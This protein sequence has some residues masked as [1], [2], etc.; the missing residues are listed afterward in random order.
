MDKIIKGTWIINS[1]KHLVDAKT[2]TLELNLLEVTEQ[3][4]KAGILLGRLV[5]DNQEIVSGE[6]LKIFSRQSG[7]TSGEILPC[8]NYLKGRGKVD[9]SVDKLGR[10]TELEV[11]CFSMEDA[12]KTTADIFENLEP[13]KIEEA[14]IYGLQSTFELPRTEAEFINEITNNNIDESI[15]REILKLQQTFGLVKS[16]RSEDDL[17]LFNEYAFTGDVNKIKKALKNLDNNEK[18]TVQFVLDT[19]MNTQGYLLDSFSSDVDRG[20]ISMME[21][22]GLIDGITVNSQ[23]GNATFLTT[24]QLRGQGVGEFKISDDVFHKA[25][26]LLSCLK[27]GQLKSSSSRGKIST[28]SKMTNIINKLLRG[29]WIGPCT[30]IGQDYQLLEIDGVI[31]TRPN[32]SGMYDMKLRQ[33]EVGLLVK[34]MITYNKLVSEMEDS[35]DDI[36]KKQPTSYTIPEARKKS[37]EAKLPKPVEEFREKMLVSLRTRGGI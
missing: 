4:G 9:F 13:Q 5:A 20:I 33:T 19:V 16:N 34:E 32:V 14:N 30:A 12:I 18:D 28:S 27:Y 11:Y 15:A 3:S 10:I 7:L 23:H 17:I 36:F 24:P 31:Q 8:V 37:I 2:N 22:V 25:K 29:S 21:G 6:N 26:I 1:V 35:F